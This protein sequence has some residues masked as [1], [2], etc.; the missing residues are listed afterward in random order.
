MFFLQFPDN[1]PLVKQSASANG[2]E[3]TDSSKPSGSTGASASLNELPGGYMGK[4]FV[5]KSGAI[6]W[7]LGEVIHDVSP[8]VSCKCF[9]DV[10]A[11]NTADENCCALGEIGKRAVV[12]P[13][14]DSLLDNVIELE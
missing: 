11:I 3:R 9:Q 10:V 5:Y 8:G 6:K 4:M 1:L 12:T 14:I 13:D 7:K 2:K